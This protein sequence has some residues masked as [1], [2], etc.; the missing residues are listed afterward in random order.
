MHRSEPGILLTILA[1]VLLIASCSGRHSPAVDTNATKFV[2][3]QP[4]D[5]SWTAIPDGEGILATTLIGNPDRPGPLVVRYD[6]PS[7]M[8]IV[9]HT[10]RENRSY[11]VISG[12]WEL[13][14]GEE[15]DPRKLA[16]YPQGG[17]YW[18]PAGVPH[19][20]RAGPEGAVIQIES[21]GPDTFDPIE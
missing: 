10:H 1:T 14:F 17:Y 21:I 15:Y 16:A 5:M 20:Q 18:L 7:G 3:A 11:T 8:E 13:G 9:A 2:G 19:F 12:I 4:K 6:I